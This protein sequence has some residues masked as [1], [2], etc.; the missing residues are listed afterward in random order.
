MQHGIIEQRRRDAA[1]GIDVR[2]IQLAAWLQQPVRRREHRRLVGD[3]VDDAVGNDH[4]EMPL[5]QVEFAELLDVALDEAHVGA[6]IAEPVPVPLEVPLCDRELRRRRIDPGNAALLTDQLRQQISVLSGPGAQIED[7][8]ALDRLGH[9]ETTAV[10]ARAHF[11]MH[12]GERGADRRRGC[13]HGAASV[14]AQ[15]ART[16][17]HLAI[18]TLAVFDVHAVA[19]FRAGVE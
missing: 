1:I 6:G 11:L 13:L 16:S 9:D 3:E 19:P 5:G 10:I 15:V 8:R 7:V 18:V 12:F 2:E 4:V 17:E 14:G